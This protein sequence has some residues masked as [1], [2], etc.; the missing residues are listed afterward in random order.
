[1]RFLSKNLDGSPRL[2]L[3]PMEGVGD[4]AFRKAMA[5]IGGFDEACTE[6]MRVPANAHVESLA[7]RYFPDETDPIPQA[8]QLMGSDPDLMAQM[9]QEVVKRG[10]PRI[11]LNCGCP[12]NTVTGRGAGSSL[13]KEPDHLYRVAKA[14]VDAVRVP[15][16]AKLRSGF[17]DTSLFREN[18]LAAQE[19]GIKFL[20][21]HPR[22]KVDGYGPPARW[23]LIAEA[24]K[25]LNIPLVGNG[26]ILTV[27][28]AINMLDQT[29]CDALMIGRGSVINP[30]VFHEIKAYFSGRP[31]KPSWER[32]RLFFD[33][34]VQ[35]IPPDMTIRGKLNKIKQIFSFL[36]K[37]NPFLLNQRNTLL[38]SSHSSVESF[39]D[40][41]IPLYQEGWSHGIKP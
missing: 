13:L 14:M 27:E 9:A 15:V 6:F 7:K 8:A 17:E 26:D 34:F 4:R 30:F 25:I 41:A 21:L 40:F 33:T 1:M 39:F 23:D 5:S 35:N 22:T 28:D 11:D 20:T 12:S 10:A 19:S 18:L 3:A 38:T 31:F 36:F 32:M 16:T 29:G 24:K 37:G 2:F